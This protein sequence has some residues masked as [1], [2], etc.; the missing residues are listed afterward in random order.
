MKRVGCGVET[1]E[2]HGRATYHVKQLFYAYS[3]MLCGL[4]FGNK[5]SINFKSLL[6]TY[7]YRVYVQTILPYNA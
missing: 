6:M 2:R 1:H 4:K 5:T 7:I 3:T